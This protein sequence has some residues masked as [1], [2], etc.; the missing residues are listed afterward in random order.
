MKYPVIVITATIYAVAIVRPLVAQS[1]PNAA[2]QAEATRFLAL[3]IS[4]DVTLDRYLQTLRSDFGHADANG[5]GVVSTADIALHVSVQSAVSRTMYASEVMVADLNGDGVVTE[6]ELREK[7]GYEERMRHVVA[8]VRHS[9]PE[10]PSPAEAERRIEQQVAR[11]M[12]ADADKDGR[13]TWKEAIA[14]FGATPDRRQMMTFG[15]ETVS[16]L[17][18]ALA[19]PGKDSV[20]LA[21]VEAAGEALFREIDADH[22]GTVSP[23]ELA[24]WRAKQSH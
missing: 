13:I 1:P 3:R 21:D 6:A 19:P 16:A 9:Q 12:A 14:Y 24:A 5:D 15:Q 22:D 8:S 17:L 10:Q 18:L 4:T 7:L 2:T 23:E 20:T 11:M